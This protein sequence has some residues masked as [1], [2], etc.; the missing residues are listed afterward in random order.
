MTKEVGVIDIGIGNLAS[1]IRALKKIGANPVLIN[2][3]KSIKNSSKLILPGVGAFGAGSNA[4]KKLELIDP[5]R[6][7][8]LQNKIPILGFCMGMQLFATRGLENGDHPGIGLIESEV[9]KLDIKKCN[10]LPHMG[11]N[12]LEST[13]GMLL[14]EDLKSNPDFY[15]VHSYHMTNLNSDISISYCNY[16]E[17][18]ITAAIQFENIYGTQFHPEKS[19]SNGM[20]VLKRFMQYA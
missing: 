19:L 4:L 10:L 3:P 16:G 11:W 14:F 5:I 9:I 20:H 7:A 8:V 17:L 1:V 15:F 12:N 6:E 13:K 2:D 18:L